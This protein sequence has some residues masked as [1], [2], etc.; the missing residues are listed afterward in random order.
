VGK[1]RK[2]QGERGW[3]WTVAVA[4]LKPILLA[5]TK[6]DWTGGEKIPASG[7][8]IIA[9]NHVSHVD[10][11]TAAHLVWDYGRESRYLAKAGLFKNKQF[12]D[13]LRAAGQ[14]PVDRSAGAD[15]FKH[16]VEAVNA[17]EIVVVYV[18]GSITKDPA[19]WPMVPKSGAARIALATGVPVIPVGQ[20]GAQALLPAYSKKPDLKGRKTI[21]MRVGD[22]VPLE[23]LRAMEITPEVVHEATDRIMNAIVGLVEEIRGEQAPPERFDPREHGMRATGNPHRKRA[24]RE[25]PE[26]QG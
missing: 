24:G 11:L 2:L 26:E 12:G 21:T 20:W 7:G 25:S 8:A 19:G 4:V 18:E 15:A 13:F 16:A 6:Q 9:L 5:T 14:I 17:G 22:P 10:P 3:A 23:D 1:Y